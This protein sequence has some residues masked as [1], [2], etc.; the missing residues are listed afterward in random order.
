MPSVA[1]SVPVIAALP[2]S[3]ETAPA[4][5]RREK[6]AHVHRIVRTVCGAMLHRVISRSTTAEISVRWEANVEG[7]FLPS[8]RAKESLVRVMDGVE[9]MVLRTTQPAPVVLG[10]FAM[11]IPMIRSVP[12][13]RASSPHLPLPASCHLCLP[14]PHNKPPHQHAELKP[15]AWIHAM[16]IEW[17]SPA[18]P[19]PMGSCTSACHAQP[20]H[21]CRE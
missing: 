14:H 12:V 5:S 17:D 21:V 9:E 4:T 3:A 10:W 16:M 13:N 7:A 1:L 15:P 18:H 2:L 8:A 11:V 19:V 6:P 20:L